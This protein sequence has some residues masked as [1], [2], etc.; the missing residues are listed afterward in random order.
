MTQ[1]HCVQLPETFIAGD[2]AVD[3]KSFNGIRKLCAP[4]QTISA[5]A[6]GGPVTLPLLDQLV[7][8]V[9]PGKPELLFMSKRTRRALKRSWTQYRH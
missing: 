7:D 5:G 6:N 9:R 3:A 1:S 2:T 4:A 8:L